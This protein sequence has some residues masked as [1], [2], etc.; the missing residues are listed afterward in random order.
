MGSPEPLPAVDPARS[1]KKEADAVKVDGTQ[2]GSDPC[3]LCAPP[4]SQLAVALTGS[5]GGRAE[6]GC[7]SH[8][9]GA[10]HL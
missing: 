4:D 7:R 8:Q 2:T 6:D 3:L 5:R 10:G 9:G 1:L